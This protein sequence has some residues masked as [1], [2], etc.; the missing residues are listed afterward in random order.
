MELIKYSVPTKLETAPWGTTWKALVGESG[1]EIY[2]QVS[3][4]EQNPQWERAGTVLEQVFQESLK[5][6]VFIER[7][8]KQHEA[9]IEQADGSTTNKFP[10]L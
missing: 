4:D 10:L 2:I 9:Q 1:H 5:D 7:I 6:E 8:L 3:R